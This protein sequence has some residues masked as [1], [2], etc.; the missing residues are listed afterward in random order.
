MKEAVWKLAREWNYQPNS[1]A[2]SLRRGKGKTIG[3]I[4]PRID[5]FFFSSVIRG[6]EDVAFDAGYHVLICQ[7]Y[8]SYQREKTIIE[9]LIN[10]KV[11]GLLVSLASETSDYSHFELVQSKNI[12]I[13]FFDRAPA[14]KNFSQVVVDDYLGAFE[15]TEHLISLG[16]R[17]IIHF[18]GPNH[19]N[20]Y[21]NRLE[22]FRAALKKHQISEITE[23][24]F[25]N[26]IV[27][28]TGEVAAY[29]IA[30]MK[31]LP[32]AIFS[33]GD[34]SALG[35]IVKLRQL[36]I[37]IPEDIA[38]V[39]FANEPYDDWLDPGLSSVDQQSF[40]MG[41][42]AANVLFEEITENGVGEP[43]NIVLAPKLIIRGSSTKK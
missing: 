4:V 39:G 33:A 41:H 42:T 23:P 27:H 29:E 31:P 38:V 25:E 2:S 1:I 22:G 34:F 6:I 13:V 32:D 17:R 19:I 43:R 10:G 24:K 26:T 37:R 3:V 18:G 5:R 9:N 12:P 11:D 30:K 35:A 28:E 40:E 21:R 16:C 20:I 14:N 15:A 7:S 36:G 8:D